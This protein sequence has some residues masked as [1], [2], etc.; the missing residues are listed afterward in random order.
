MPTD[1]SRY[2]RNWQEISARIRARAGNRC[3]WCGA[4]NHAPHPVTGSRVVLTVAHLDDDPKNNADGN[5]A[6]PCQRC[7]LQY[8][9]P[10]HAAHARETSGASAKPPAAS[11]RS[12]ISRR[13]AA[14]TAVNRCVAPCSTN[15]RDIMADEYVTTEEVARR[16]R[17]SE[18]TVRR[19]CRA[20][21]LPTV[22]I[23]RAHRIPLAAVLAFAAGAALTSGASPARP[24]GAP[25]PRFAAGEGAAGPAAGESESAPEGDGFPA[26]RLPPRR[27]PPAVVIGD[28]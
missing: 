3:E 25:D 4:E 5:L 17:V 18:E 19:W 28:L 22:Q 24:E 12:S 14:L 7:H 20:G 26:G 9:A 8:D 10:V 27:L 16:L 15:R 1:R 21:R 6:A 2:P 13:P 11:R 23:G